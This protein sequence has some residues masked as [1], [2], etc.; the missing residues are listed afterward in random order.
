MRPGATWTESQI[1][2]TAFALI[3]D[4]TGLRDF[5]PDADFVRDLK[6]D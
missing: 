5:D 2:T 3:R 1:R 4:Q 6:L